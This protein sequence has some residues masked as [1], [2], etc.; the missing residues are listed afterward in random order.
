MATT[1]MADANIPARSALLV[2]LM[3]IAQVF[4]E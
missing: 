2:K 4:T 3:A 1:T